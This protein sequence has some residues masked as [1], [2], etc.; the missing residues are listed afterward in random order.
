M[1]S[2]FDQLDPRKIRTTSLKERK[3]TIGVDDFSRTYTKGSAFGDFYEALPNI[4]AGRDFRRIVRSLADAF[5]EGRVTVL[6]MGAHPIKVG[7]SP[8]HREPHRKGSVQGG[9]HERGVRHPRCGS[10]HGRSYF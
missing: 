6:A 1:K 8:H 7:L 3:S 10:R 4:L 5:R 2:G 9:G